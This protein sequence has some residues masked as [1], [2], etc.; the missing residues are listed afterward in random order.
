MASKIDIE[1]VKSQV[2]KA[3]ETL[4]RAADERI[5]WN[6]PTAGE[7]HG[8]DS[9]SYTFLPG[10]YS[11]EPAG[12]AASQQ[13]I[14]GGDPASLSSPAPPADGADG[15]IRIVLHGDNTFEYVWTMKRRVGRGM[16][17]MVEMTGSWHKPMLNRTRRGELDQ[18]VFLSAD[19]VRFQRLSNYGTSSTPPDVVLVL[20]QPLITLST[21]SQIARRRHGS[22]A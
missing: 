17:H 11:L 13:E 22:S 19:R 20:D 1:H 18:R 12:H 21:T 7:S 8:P 10:V 2:V 3:M 6:Q 15:G 16:K 5:S 9:A 14:D 4:L